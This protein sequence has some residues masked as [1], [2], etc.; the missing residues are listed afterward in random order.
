MAPREAFALPAGIRGGTRHGL[1]GTCRRP[2]P[3][4]LASAPVYASIAAGRPAQAPS[5]LKEVLVRDKMHV[6]N[7]LEHCLRS[8]SVRTA[9]IVDAMRYSLLAGGKR[10]RPIL[11]LAAYDMF[12]AK[13]GEDHDLFVK[14]RDAAALPAALAVEMIHTMSL[15]HDD[16]PD[17]DN[18]DF[19][20][21]R[22]TC[23]KAY[24]VDIAILAGDALLAYAYEF[25]ARHTS[26]VDPA[27][28]LRVISLLGESVGAN[29]LVG[30]QVMDLDA[31]GRDDVTLDDLTWIHTHKTATLLRV[32][33]AAGAILGGANDEDVARVTE[34]AI[35]TGLAF[36]IT[37]DVLD[38][39]ASTDVLGKT[40]GKDI[41]ASKATFPRL[42]GLERSRNEASKLTTEAKA[43]LAP[44]GARAGTLLGLADFIISR[45]N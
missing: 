35:K 45:A 30:G 33:V 1:C 23:H 41:E 2:S 5:L 21:G 24:G 6:D 20:R 42:L 34:F 36:Q 17:M 12:A 43:C 44:Y 31:E 37:D 26:G 16:L 25:V 11:L 9:K 40:A 14:R 32:S 15:I 13:A 38:V 8:D 10:I 28:V 27:R 39:T 29:G 3:R 4:R 22:P 18:D 7:A 19:R